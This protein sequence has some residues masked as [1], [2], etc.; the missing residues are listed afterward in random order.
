MERRT[1]SHVT[2]VNESR[3]TYELVTSHIDRMDKG[4]R[5]Q[6]C[7]RLQHTATY[8]LQHTSTDLCAEWAQKHRRKTQ[9]KV[10]HTATHCNTCAAT[11]YNLLLYRMGKGGKKKDSV[12]SSREAARLFK[13]VRWLRIVAQVSGRELQCVAVC[14][15]VLQCV[16]VCC[17]VCAGYALSHK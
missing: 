11:P 1:R 5:K 17:S 2:G 3:H 12:E 7:N 9:M 4:A 16:A 15:S 6:H 8:V 10:R 13:C 14:C